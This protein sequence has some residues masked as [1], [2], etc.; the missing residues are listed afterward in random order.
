MKHSNPLQ[1]AA[2]QL[3]Q[4]PDEKMNPSLI[5]NIIGHT[6]ELVD[7]EITVNRNVNHLSMREPENQA[8]VPL[9]SE[10]ELAENL[11]TKEQE[12]Y[13]KLRG[14]ALLRIT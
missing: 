10:N 9:R 6:E 13:Q 5:Q 1:I 2:A 12:E 8:Y 3:E 7:N 14:E 4:H 11:T